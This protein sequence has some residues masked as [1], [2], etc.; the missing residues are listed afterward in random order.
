MATTAPIVEVYF[1]PPRPAALDDAVVVVLDILRATT[2]HAALFA[3]GA[4]RVYPVANFAG[5]RDLR[6][7]LAAMERDVF[8]IGEVNALPPPEADFGNSP[9]QF[10][11]LDLQS[12]EFVH[13]TSNGTNTLLGARG[14]ALTLSACLRNMTATLERALSEHPSRLV[15]VCSG[16]HGGTAPSV[17]DAFAAGAFVDCVR[18]LAPDAILRGG[19]RLA[20]KLF[21]AYDANPQAAFADSPHADHLLRLGFDDDLAYAGALDAVSTVIVL[22]ADRS[23]RAVLERVPTLAH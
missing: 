5:G 10:A 1:Q 18:R 13:V 21:T 20:V 2:V 11:S 12:A 15:I 22:G 4:Q 6:D 3:A 16:D 19:A 17:E 9:T 14:A 23:G 8:L 7:D